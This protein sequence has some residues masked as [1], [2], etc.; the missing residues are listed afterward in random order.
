MDKLIYEKWFINIF[1]VI[2]LIYIPFYLFLFYDEIRIRINRRRL[3]KKLKFTYNLTKCKYIHP[4]YNI[5]FVHTD[6]KRKECSIQ[7]KKLIKEKKNA[8]SSKV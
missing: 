2:L 4:D 3:E 5:T 6:L 7:I 8:K 1:L